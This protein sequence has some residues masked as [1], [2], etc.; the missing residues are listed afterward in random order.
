MSEPAHVVMGPNC[1]RCLNCG[2]EQDFPDRSELSIVIAVMR[3][4]GENH[5]ECPATKEGAKRFD[6]SNAYE[7]SRSWDTGISSLTIFSV[8]T[9]EPLQCSRAD[10]PKDPEDFGRC[11]RL[12]DVAPEWR[13]RLQ[14]VADRY[15]EWEP[16]VKNW[17]EL[18][19][20]YRQEIPSGR[21]PILYER[22]QNLAKVPFDVACICGNPGL[23]GPHFDD[24][25]NYG[26]C[27]CP[28]CDGGFDNAPCQCDD[29]DVV[30]FTPRIE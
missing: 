1:V 3:Q 29:K 11:V 16:L 21:A 17:P 26:G 19:A 28:Y 8:L 13:N 4:F 24:V 23:E 20:L 27:G 6:Y 2:R 14:A 10:T 30:H 5:A 18:E 25:N 12:L 15:P 7:W 9:G 22:M